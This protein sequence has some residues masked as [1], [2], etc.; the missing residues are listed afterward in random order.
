[1]I[2]HWYAMITSHA[3]VVIFGV[4]DCGIVVEKINNMLCHFE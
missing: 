1:M 3:S 4:N 2:N